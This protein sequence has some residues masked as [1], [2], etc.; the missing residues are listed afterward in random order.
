[1]HHE[2]QPELDI[3]S[4]KEVHVPADGFA[5]MLLCQPGLQ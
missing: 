1:M 4:R 3:T 5:A 2:A